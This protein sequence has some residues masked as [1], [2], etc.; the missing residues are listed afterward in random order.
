M[1]FPGSDTDPVYSCV[2]YKEIGCSHVDGMFCNMKT[3]DILKDHKRI[4]MTSKD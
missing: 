3:C 4:I 1:M 2:V